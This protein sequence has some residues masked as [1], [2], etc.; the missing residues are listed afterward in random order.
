MKKKSRR[1]FLRNTSLSVLSV[2]AVPGMLKAEQAV[3]QDK[4]KGQEG[5]CEP[6]TVD[7]YGQGPFYTPNAPFIQNGQ[8]A[9]PSELGQRL[10]ISGRVLNLDCT[11]ALPNTEIDVWHADSNG[12]YDNT[13]YRLRG[14]VNANSQ[15]FYL[16]ETV[17]PGFYLNGASYRPAHIHFRITP[18]G[19]APLITQ[20]YFQGDPYIASDA[21][22]SISSGAYDATHRIIPLNTNANN[23][24]EGSWDIVLDGN[25]VP[26]GASELHLEKGMIYSAFSNPFR[27][28]LEI[29]YGVF[30]RSK[31]AIAVYDL[32]GQQLAVLDEQSMEAG[33]YSVV[34]QPPLELPK[35]HYFIS[36]Q[37]NDLQVHYIKVLRG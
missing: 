12:A 15:G 32:Q 31:V 22:A 30:Q 23:E 10:I 34:W 2:A 29:E 37:I 24:L 6:S 1:A 4:E 36:I 27:E 5:N 18:P 20:L 14:R 8:L 3:E 28:E 11:L 19:F 25:G 9:D 7:Y 16:F 13:G 17:M 21:A 35:G 33:K 26:I